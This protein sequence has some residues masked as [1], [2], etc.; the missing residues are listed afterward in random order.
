[1]RSI[2]CTGVCT[3]IGRNM[4]YTSLVLQVV[5]SYI[6]KCC[7]NDVATLNLYVI[8]TE[9]NQ[10]MS[11][12][13]TTVHL[14]K[15]ELMLRCNILSMK[16]RFKKQPFQ[17]DGCNFARQPFG[18]PNMQVLTVCRGHGVVRPEGG[19]SQCSVWTVWLTGTPGCMCRSCAHEKSISLNFTTHL[20]INTCT[21]GLAQVHASMPLAAFTY[22]IVY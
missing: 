3:V 2:Q 17:P 13:R 16:I 22:T 9:L 11:P 7:C 15:D 19:V 5:S 4:H 12:S 1:M 18:R 8:K 20:F 10:A 6:C 21:A 14:N